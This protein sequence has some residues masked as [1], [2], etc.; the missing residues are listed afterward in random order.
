MVPIKRFQISLDRVLI[1][2]LADPAQELGLDLV[3]GDRGVSLELDLGDR[4][5]RETCP[6]APDRCRLDDERED[7]DGACQ[8][9]RPADAVRA[10]PRGFRARRPGRAGKPAVDAR[11]GASTTVAAE[12]AASFLTRPAV[13]HPWCRRSRAFVK[14]HVRSFLNRTD[15]PPERQ[16]TSSDRRSQEQPDDS[17][18]SVSCPPRKRA[19]KAIFD[20]VS[21]IIPGGVRAHRTRLRKILRATRCHGPIADDSP[22]SPSLAHGAEKPMRR[23]SVT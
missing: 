1:E 18:L 6:L 21:P 2:R 17:R 23:G 15:G 19:E 16:S 12:P 14:S 13:S 10:A 9:D 4:V 8:T 3:G 7:G 22:P 11:A 5:L 20:R